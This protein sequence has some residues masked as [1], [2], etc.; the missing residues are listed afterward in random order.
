VNQDH[1]RQAA[2]HF[3]PGVIRLYTSEFTRISP[4]LVYEVYHVFAP[5]LSMGSTGWLPCNRAGGRGVTLSPML[6]T[7]LSQA[8]HVRVAINSHLANQFMGNH[9]LDST[10]RPLVTCLVFETVTL[11]ITPVHARLSR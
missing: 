4:V 11:L 7:L 1:D 5:R 6:A 2:C 3:G 9:V 10:M 8:G